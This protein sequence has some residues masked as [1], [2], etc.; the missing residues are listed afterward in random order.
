MTKPTQ[1]TTCP[2]LP[3]RISGL[4]GDGTRD[5]R[6]KKGNT[7]VELQELVEEVSGVTSYMTVTGVPVTAT[8]LKIVN[9]K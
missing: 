8:E 6:Y 9:E 5:K 4:K 2:K 1:T 3:R 7:M